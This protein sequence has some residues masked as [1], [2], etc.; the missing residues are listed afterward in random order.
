MQIFA[1]FEHSINIELAITALEDNGIKDIFAVP[2]ENTPKDAQVIGAL[3]E[4][5]GNTFMTVG[6][7]LAV[8]FSVLG[9]SAGFKFALGP[10]YWGLF[11]AG[12]GYLVGFLADLIKNGKNFFKRR[13]S[14]GKKTEVIL[15]IDCEKSEGEQVEKILWKQRAFGIAKVQ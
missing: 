14:K 13:L 1:T 11:G 2:L 4:S 10:I 9:A 3:H 12:L 5:D 8:I 15:I 6:S 7:F